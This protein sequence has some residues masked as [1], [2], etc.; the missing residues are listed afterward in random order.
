MQCKFKFKCQLKE[1]TSEAN[2]QN[3]NRQDA[4]RQAKRQEASDNTTRYKY[5]IVPIA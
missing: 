2:C 1:A 4:K 3:A 5:K